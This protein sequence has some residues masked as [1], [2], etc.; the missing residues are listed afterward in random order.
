MIGFPY[1]DLAGWRGPYSPEVFA[2]QWEKVSAGWTD[3]LAELRQAVDAAP[4][5][6]RPAA[7][8]DLRVAGAAGLHFASVGHQARFVVARDGDRSRV[9]PILDAEI[10]CTRELFDLC[11]A[12]SR[13]GFEASNHYYYVPL[14]LVEKVINCEYLRSRLAPTPPR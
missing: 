1:D 2:R 13:I 6:K 7:E 12:D 5:E 10:R 11:R 14:D 9:G 4:S 3:G 8:A